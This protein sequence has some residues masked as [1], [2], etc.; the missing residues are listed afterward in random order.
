MNSFWDDRYNTVQYVY[1]REANGYF[2]AEL[3]KMPPGRILLPGDGEGRNSVHAALCGW[4]AVAFDQSAVAREKALAFASESGVSLDYALSSLEDYAFAAG[5]YDVV[6]L[7]FFHASPGQ[8]VYLHQ[9]A[10]K[11][12][13][14]GGRLILEAFHKEQLGRDSGGPGSPDYLFD[15]QTILS[16]FAGLET[17]HLEKLLLTL[18]EGPF[19]QGEA[20]VLRYTGIKPD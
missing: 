13:K 11:A 10:I 6:A 5:Q 3:S 15:E 14:P 20:S 17:L 7:V 1:G 4:K 12:L 16:D 2:S 9:Q 18:N 19:H 8:R